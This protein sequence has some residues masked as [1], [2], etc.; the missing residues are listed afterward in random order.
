LIDGRNIWKN[1]YSKSLQVIR[2]VVE[3]LGTDRVLL[4]PSCSLLHVPCDLD[5]EQKLEA[6]IK[7]W[8]AFAKQKVKEV[9]DL[10]IIYSEQQQGTS[11][12]RLK[13]NQVAIASRN[14]SDR[15]H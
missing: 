11:S 3:K 5:L 15:I 1:D 14:A 9:T 6:E 10:K 7:Q 2:Q 13:E 8:L 12:D 4:A